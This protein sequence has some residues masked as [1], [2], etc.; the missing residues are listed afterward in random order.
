MSKKNKNINKKSPEL[1]SEKKISLAGD[2]T[3]DDVQKSPEK[4]NDKIRELSLSGEFSIGDDWDD[5]EV[6]N[7]EDI[8][9]RLYLDAESYA[10]YSDETIEKHFKIINGFLSKLL[11]WKSQGI[12]LERTYPN[13]NLDS[14]ITKLKDA[15]SNLDSEPKRLTA[16]TRFVEAKKRLGKQTLDNMLGAILADQKLTIE[17]SR[18]FIS[19]AAEWKYSPDDAA[20]IL[21]DTI[22]QKNYQALES[23][24]EHWSPLKKLTSS[25]WATPES[26]SNSKVE[27]RLGFGDDGKTVIT[28]L[29][30]LGKYY[31]NNRK[32][33]FELIK[34]RFIV[35]SITSYF[36]VV[37]DKLSGFIDSSDDPEIV[38]L[39]CIY[40]LN[41]KLPFR[42]NEKIE[43]NSEQ[44]LID[45]V[46]NGDSFL[47]N[48]I[49]D[50]IN[51]K[52]LILWWRTRNAGIEKIISANLDEINRFQRDIPNNSL[53]IKTK[54]TSEVNLLNSTILF[55]ILYSIQP[56]L[57]YYYYENKNFDTLDNLADFLYKECN[58]DELILEQLKYNVLGHW[59]FLKGAKKN[60]KLIRLEMLC[61]QEILNLT[62]LRF[63]V[64]YAINPKLPFYVEEDF[65][66]NDESK[67]IES[68]RVN[69]RNWEKLR[70]KVDDGSFLL[71]LKFRGC[72]KLLD[73]LTAKKA[74]LE[75]KELFDKDVNLDILLRNLA[76][77]A[78]DV[79]LKIEPDSL[80]LGSLAKG[81]VKE[82]SVTINRTGIGHVRGKIELRLVSHHEN[83][84]L[85][86]KLS[87]NEFSIPVDQDKFTFFVEINNSED[88]G[89]A[90]E[91][92]IQ[93]IT[94]YGDYQLPV[95][96]DS[97]LPIKML[98]V[99]GFTGAIGFGVVFALARWLLVWAC[100]KD[101]M[102]EYINPPFGYE[103]L[104][105]IKAVY[106]KILAAF[107]ILLIAIISSAG[108][109]VSLNKE[110]KNGR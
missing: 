35:K 8:F 60:E 24:E 9:L 80:Q 99:K 78:T 59:Y 28:N 27:F 16:Y 40:A 72:E 33:A 84:P 46:I 67:T 41:H 92:H 19:S 71:W 56:D 77:Q 20:K 29:A 44:D 100:G 87:A 26:I 96:Y 102:F 107:I 101:W 61:K 38:Y 65:I 51:K 11:N 103:A 82:F 88:L 58:E 69:T 42:L 74:E 109:L 23:I 110:V 14:A 104:V 54:G 97:Q 6:L 7:S 21:F 13:L 5:Y 79:V 39:N 47:I 89:S 70:N 94:N 25:E 36:P 32:T 18:L 108:F 91:Y 2:Q 64:S 93:F 22:S 43:L 90:V 15:K 1:A 49:V 37:A 57:P 98:L 3:V 83:K 86:P 12:S 105:Q 53:K 52:Q 85:E 76:S 63:L 95:S 106:W 4:I 75:K 62:D 17:E 55:R 45:T 81:T 30:D 68:V 34:S 48:S 73:S 31:Y 10:S 66:I 50:S